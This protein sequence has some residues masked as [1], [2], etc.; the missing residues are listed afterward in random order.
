MGVAQNQQVCLRYG[1]CTG[2]ILYENR[3]DVNRTLWCGSQGGAEPVG[4]K[5]SGRFTRD[6]TT[7]ALRGFGGAAAPALT[8]MINMYGPGGEAPAQQQQ[9]Q[10]QNPSQP[11]SGADGGG[12]GGPQGQV[13]RR[14][15]GSTSQHSKQPSS[16]S[17]RQHSSGSKSSSGSRHAP[18]AAGAGVAG[19]TQ[20]AAAGGAMP[21]ILVPSGE[22]LLVCLWETV[23]GM[24]HVLCVYNSLPACLLACLLACLPANLVPVHHR[25]C[26]PCCTT[27]VKFANAWCFQLPNHLSLPMVK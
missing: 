7:D 2:R 19:H 10:P 1:S 15:S 6:V 17:Q 22:G 8:Q 26:G 27:C 3:R 14:G 9:P 25:G 23:T 20:A 4:A 13:D 18:A 16:G 5:P 21:I 24:I 12:M 11:P